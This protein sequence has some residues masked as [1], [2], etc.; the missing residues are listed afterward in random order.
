MVDTI[1]NILG[2]PPGVENGD[3][4]DALASVKATCDVDVRDTHS[5]HESE[6]RGPNGEYAPIPVLH[7][8]TA[9]AKA[10]GAVQIAK[11]QK[12]GPSP[13][14]T[15]RQII[16]DA[17]D[18]QSDYLIECAL[19][20]E[21]DQTVTTP[22]GLIIPA[23]QNINFA[24]IPGIA[25]CRGLFNFNACDRPQNCQMQ[26]I[27]RALSLTIGSSMSNYPHLEAL[28]RHLYTLPGAGSHVKAPISWH[29]LMAKCCQ[30]H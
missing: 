8:S 25:G 16:Q 26:D 1:A 3:A 12:I 11:R 21:K 7:V 18:A 6:D 2:N 15:P 28:L 19:S 24:A 23:I 4:Q 20:M 27:L 9:P 5:D 29:V 30:F 13:S 10:D 14:K 22:N 17:I